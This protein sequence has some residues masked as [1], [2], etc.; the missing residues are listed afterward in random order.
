MFLSIVV[1]DLY[2]L[3][4]MHVS[5]HAHACKIPTSEAIK[6]GTAADAEELNLFSETGANQT[7]PN[8]S[9]G[10]SRQAQQVAGAIC[11]RGAKCRRS[12][13]ARTS[14]NWDR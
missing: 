13:R 6:V 7:H 3:G 9:E 11:K 5:S 8:E 12:K 2:P 10:R 4:Y 14:F 1:P